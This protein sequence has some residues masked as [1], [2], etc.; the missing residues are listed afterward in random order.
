[1]AT[2]NNVRAHRTHLKPGAGA[3]AYEAQKVSKYRQVHQFVPFIIETGGRIADTARD[4]IDNTLLPGASQE[5]K[6]ARSKL[7]KGIVCN[8]ERIQRWMMVK[9][10]EDLKPRVPRRTH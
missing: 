1:V 4:F 5:N 2:E 3:K 10:L 6:R 9:I 8:L 7:Y